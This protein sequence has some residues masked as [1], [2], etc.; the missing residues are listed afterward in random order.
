MLINLKSFVT[1]PFTDNATF[2]FDKFSTIVM[3]AQR[4]MDDMVDIEIE[5]I[6]KIISKINKDPEPKA[7]KNIELNLWKNIRDRAKQGRRTGLGITAVGDTLAAL[8]IKYGSDQS[9]ESIESIYRSLA[10]ASYRS[11][12]QL[13]KERGAFPIH[14]HEREANHEFL[15]RIFAADH[16]IEVLNKTYGRRNIALTTTAPAGSVSVLTQTSSG[17][18]PAFLL[19]YTR[20]KKLTENDVDPRVDFIDDSGDKWQEFDVYHHG[21]K[22]WMDVTGLKKITDSPYFEACSNDINWVQKVKV[23]AAAQR[24]VCHAISNTTNLPSDTT[25]ETVKDV[26]MAGW[27]LGCKG[28]TVYRDGCRSGVLIGTSDK[29]DN[30]KNPDLVENANK[31]PDV[32]DCEIHRATI[33]GEDWTILVG[34]M[35]DR[36]YEIFGGLSEY[37]E[38]PKKY[39]QGRIRKRP[40]KTMLSKYDLT[41]GRNGDEIIIKDI[42]KVFDN[43]NHSAF[44]RTLSL[45]LRHGVPIHYLVEQL[46]KDKDADLFSLSRVIARCLKK[47]IKDG[48][49][50]G[51]GTI[52]CNC[53]SIEQ[54][55]VIYQEGCAICLTC[56]ASKC[57]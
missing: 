27:I 2:D 24:W 13:A 33:K 25:I 53:T 55:N 17:I 31:R 9:I 37:V 48:T 15:S 36:P 46:Q 12:C 47:Y 8:G 57:G 3:K 40:R 20:R 18:E 49:R 54:S 28:V 39:G 1:D 11:S 32:L 4:L 16:E 35:N 6:D 21:F 26:Y 22:Q 45:T 23:Q 7:V 10:I 5:Q 52:T 19:K 44:S 43:P 29:N 51:N 34:I 38:I 41:I 30:S 56:G 50:A 42:V 14:D